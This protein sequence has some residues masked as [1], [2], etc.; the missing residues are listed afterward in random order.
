MIIKSKS[1]TYLFDFDG[2]LAGMNEWRS[3]WKNN[4]SVFTTGIYINPHKYDIRWSILT[5]RPRIDF[6]MIKL[7][8]MIY[9]LYPTNILCS[10]DLFF[11]NS[12]TS[13]QQLDM[14]VDT[15]V[16]I[17]MGRDDRFDGVQKVF[18]IDNDLEVVKYIN[19]RRRLYIGDQCHILP[20]LAITSFDFVKQEF[21][22]YI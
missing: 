4:V 18:Y 7:A 2:T 1:C 10:P 8:C 14:K 13:H 21:D 5:G 11:D 22:L 12:K 20:F 19:S 3:V 6:P 9:G 16:S 17:L 15:I